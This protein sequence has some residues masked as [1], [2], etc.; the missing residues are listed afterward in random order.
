[1]VYP[2][3]VCVCVF[4]GGYSVHNKCFSNDGLRREKKL[5]VMKHNH[6]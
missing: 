4:L 1:M 3:Y 2:V 6:L 5:A